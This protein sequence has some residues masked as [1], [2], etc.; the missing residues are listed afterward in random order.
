M[1]KRNSPVVVGGLNGSGTRV[2]AE[3][4]KRA[5][6][7]MGSDFNKASD[8]LWFTLLL[9]R[10]EWYLSHQQPDD[11]DV[12]YVID[13][14]ERIMMG[15]PLSARD[16]RY[17]LS[18]A[19]WYSFEQRSFKS[20]WVIRR[21]R[22]M[23]SRNE[24]DLTEHRGW[25]WKEPHSHFYLPHLAHHY[26]GLRYIQVIRHGLDMA[27]GGN[28]EQVYKWARALGL[29]APSDSD[30]AERS[31][32]FWIAAN[33]RAINI[34]QE[35][36]GECF[37]LLRYDHLCENPHEHIENLFSFLEVSDVDIEPL[38]K[39][40]RISRTTG[41]YRVHDNSMFSTSK[42]QAVRAFGFDVEV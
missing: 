23:L 35:T 8:N 34:G 14:L 22:N 12:Q 37:F 4:L 13:L 21:L 7:Y 19:T 20:V 31:L 28:Q 11:R 16:W 10:P 32:D 30:E 39:I 5:G 29:S 40:P 6:F 36:L 26:P 27:Y 25:G 9:K 38:A 24:L 41:R 33:H 2:V 42:I 1:D 3:I 17:I 18:A 15:E